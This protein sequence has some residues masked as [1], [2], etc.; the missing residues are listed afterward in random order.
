MESAR[1]LLIAASV[2]A[3]LLTNLYATQAQTAGG[4][5]HYFTDTGHYVCNEFLQFFET[6]GGVEIFG[7]PVSEAFDD[8]ARGLR[9]QYFQC[10]RMELHPYNSDPYK[11]QLG[12]LADELGY[13]YPPARPEQIPAFNSALHYYFHE[14]SHVVSYAFL[15]YFSEHGGVDIFGYPRSEFMYE[16]GYIVQY[17][18]RAR[19][20]WHPEYTTGPQMHLTY[21]GETYLERFPISE[22]YTQPQP[23]PLATTDDSASLS[24]GSVTRLD[25]S[26]SVRY[27]ITGRKG[28]QTVFVYVNDQQ[29]KPVQN[30]VVR[31]TI[32][33]PSDTQTYDLPAT[34]ASG[35]TRLSFDI[36][37]SPPGQKVVIDVTV[38]YGGLSSTTQTFFLP[39]W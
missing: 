14:T 8:P 22:E 9:V 2:A 1:K 31:M 17:F 32:R 10:A 29:Q 26:A 38:T 15:E 39:W 11:V 35:F 21:L 27:V 12:L 30:A 5:C 28:T 25:T 6:R 16:D 37:L 19:M 34:S 3:L 36:R 7:F 24:V 20:E 4:D 18:Q 13:T 23:P 33:Y